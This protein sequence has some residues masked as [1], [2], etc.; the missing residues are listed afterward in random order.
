MPRSAQCHFQ[1]GTLSF[2]YELTRKAVKNINLRIRLDGSIH[3]SAPSFVSKDRIDAFLLRET[4]FIV[5]TL[6][7]I[8]KKPV[9]R[10]NTGD[11][12]YIHGRPLTLRVVP[13]PA[14][15][16]YEKGDILYM[17]TS[18]SDEESQRAHLYHQYLRQQAGTL[19]AAS[20]IPIPVPQHTIP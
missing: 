10:L 8:E 9:F 20:D 19:F 17:E 11:V 4:P 15:K 6:S 2:S 16:V 13:G 1:N 14:G 7:Q 5:K 12:L 3:V 18:H